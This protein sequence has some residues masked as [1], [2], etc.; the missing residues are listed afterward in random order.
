QENPLCNDNNNN[1]RLEVFESHNYEIA[2]LPNQI[3]SIGTSKS[4]R[5]ELIQYENLNIFGTQF[6]PEMSDDGKKLIEKF[7]KL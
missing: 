5:H 3:S 1:T 7:C 6:H 4:C 2:R